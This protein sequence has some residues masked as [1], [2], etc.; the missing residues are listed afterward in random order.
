[1]AKLYF[2]YGAMGS[3]KTI[4]LLKVAYNYE[5]RDQKVIILTS[6]IDDRY[7]LG[8]V[9]TRIGLQKDAEIFKQDTNIYN[10]VR[11]YGYIADCILIDEAQFLN[12]KQVEEISDIV[13]KLDIPVICYGLRADFRLNFFEGSKYLMEIADKIEEI[14][15]I[16]ECGAKATC[17]MRLI[18][19]KATNKGEQILIGGNDSYKSV[20][21]KCYKKYIEG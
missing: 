2:R 21:R 1:M 12:K 9:T 5:E 15:T 3:G 18:D 19:G 11:D 13:D 10:L 17:N 14:K 4:D 20:C 6:G 8:K 7:G 16:C